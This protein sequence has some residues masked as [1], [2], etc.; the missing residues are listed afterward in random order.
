MLILIGA[1]FFSVSLGF[2]NLP[3]WISATIVSF[4][5][6]KYTVLAL[7]TIVY[8]ILGCLVD[9][10]SMIVMT[11]PMFL[12]LAQTYGMDPIWFGIFIVLLVQIANITPPVGFNLFLVTGLADESIGFISRSVM[13]FIVIIVVFAF[14]LAAFPQI[15]LFLPNLMAS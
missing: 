3:K 9:G 6:G 15:V 10:Y 13:P 11:V 14:L 12:P 7:M 5:A 2:L 4:G 1:S 8:L